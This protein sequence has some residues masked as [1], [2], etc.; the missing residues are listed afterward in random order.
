MV[1]Q[2]VG[3]RASKGVTLVELL[4]VVTIL[5]VLLAMATPFFSDLAQNNRLRGAVN[6]FTMHFRLA[7]TESLKNNVGVSINMQTDATSNTWCYGLSVGSTCQCNRS[8]TCTLNNQQHVVS[9]ESYLGLQMVPGVSNNRFTFQPKRGTVTAGNVTFTA[10]NGNKLR[11]VINGYGRIR[12]CVP[13]N[14]P[15]LGGYPTC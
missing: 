15:R 12:V 4:S 1:L 8:T 2:N 11:A 14:Y 9:S 3:M 10:A 13:A 5:G 7:M 6:E